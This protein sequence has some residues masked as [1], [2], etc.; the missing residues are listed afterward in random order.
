MLVVMKPNAEAEQVQRVCEKAQAGGL[1]THVSQGDERT[2]IGL[3]G[4][5]RSVDPATYMMVDGVERVSR[6][7]EPYKLAGRTVQPQDSIVD[8]GSCKVGSAEVCLIAGPC[9]VESRQQILETAA[10]VKEA[11]ATA[12]RGGA[13]KPRTSPYAFQGMGERGLELLAEARQLTGLPIV[14]EVMGIEELERVCQLS[15]VLQLGARNMQNFNLLRAVS[16]R[17]KAVLLKRGMMNTMEELLMSAEYLL[18]GGNSQVM[19]CER[20]I[21]TFET[22]TRNTF[23]INAIPELKRRTHLPVLADPSHATGRAALVTPVAQAA[24]AAGA[25][26]LIVEVHPQPERAASD[27]LQSLR[28]EQFAEMVRGVRAVAEAVGRSLYPKAQLR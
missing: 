20:G 8:I 11:G 9:S 12:L 5:V 25:D 3:L 7:G 4:D 15:D 26:G 27:G 2:I 16:R 18:A 14:T 24:V 13:F 23:D 21:R 6:I 19:L 17:D 22:Y 1:R 28:P 10:A